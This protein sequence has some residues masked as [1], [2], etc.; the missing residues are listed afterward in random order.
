MARDITKRK[1]TENLKNY[2]VNAVSHQIRNPLYAMQLNTSFLLDG[3]IEIP[4]TVNDSINE[5]DVGINLRQPDN[6]PPV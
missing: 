4:D 3:F 2:F 5:I 1:E 6:S